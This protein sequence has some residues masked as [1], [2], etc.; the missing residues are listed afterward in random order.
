MITCHKIEKAREA[1]ITKLK[2][3]NE[4]MNVDEFTKKIKYV[5]LMFTRV[6]K[7]FEKYKLKPVV[8]LV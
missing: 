6:I 2:I 3:K 8:K 5:D 1:L 4:D 7:R